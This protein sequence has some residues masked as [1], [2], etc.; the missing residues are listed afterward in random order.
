MWIPSSVVA[1]KL[2]VPVASSKRPVPPTKVYVP[3]AVVREVNSPV[4]QAQS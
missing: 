1:S 4:K 2:A 3:S